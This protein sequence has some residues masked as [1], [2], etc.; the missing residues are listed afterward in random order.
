VAPDVFSCSCGPGGYPSPTKHP[1]LFG[2]ELRAD[3]QCLLTGVARVEGDG[4]R[5]FRRLEATGMQRVEKLSG[6]VLQVDDECLKGK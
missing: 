6:E 4:L 3:P 2:L 1:F 5:G